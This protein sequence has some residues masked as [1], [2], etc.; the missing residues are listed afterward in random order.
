MHGKCLGITVESDARGGRTIVVLPDLAILPKQPMFCGED[1][2][3]M[4]QGRGQPSRSAP[5]RG[6]HEMKIGSSHLLP[7]RVEGS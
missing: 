2:R 1:L 3:M 7:I 4:I 5:W 6:D